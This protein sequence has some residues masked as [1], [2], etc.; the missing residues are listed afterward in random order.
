MIVINE[1]KKRRRY[2]FQGDNLK[3]KYRSAVNVNQI[4]FMT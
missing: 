2:I 1:G 4:T 3:R